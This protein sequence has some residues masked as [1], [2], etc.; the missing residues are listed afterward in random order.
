MSRR[1]LLFAGL[2]GVPL[3]LG[4]GALAVRRPAAQAPLRTAFWYWHHP[5][6]LSPEEQKRLKTLGVERLY[7]HAGTLSLR[8]GK[9]VA[10]S[11]QEWKSKPAPELHAVVRVHPDANSRFLQASAEEVRSLLAG[12]RLPANVQGVQ[13][14]ADIPTRR[15]PEYAAFLGRC[16]PALPPGAILG[17]TA[18]PDWLG[19]RDYPTLCRSLDEISPQFYGNH[20]PLPGKKPPPLWETAGFQRQLARAASGGIPVWAGLPSYGRVWVLD[21]H[22]RALGLRHDLDPQ[23]LLNDAT[24]T[25]Q[26]VE[27]RRDASGGGEPVPVEDE[28]RL[29][30]RE[31]SSAGPIAAPVGTTLHFQWPRVDALQ[32]SVTALR[33][34]RPAGVA[35]VCY[36]R[37]PAPGEPLSLPLSTTEPQVRVTRQG[38]RVAVAVAPGT[39]AGGPVQL[40]VFPAGG[41]VSAPGEIEWRQ[42][43]VRSSSLRADRAILTS[44][45]LIPGRAWIACTITG[46]RGPVR[47]SLLPPTPPTGAKP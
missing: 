45:F 15:L 26:P 38:N 4:A 11:M 28:L 25:A 36:F 3:V 31:S 35:G 34:G 7:V 16:R 1:V 43:E 41:E 17:A 22:G 19:S 6:R 13:W 18:L 32:A 24:W 20:W 40:A 46:A 27:T 47:A 44:P 5:F 12:L 10:E 9:L 2:A 39:A 42:G 29:V 30:C 8:G 21:R 37:W 23:P 14:D 33:H